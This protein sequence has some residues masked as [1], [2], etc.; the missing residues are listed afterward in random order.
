MHKSS[1]QR[2]AIVVDVRRFPPLVSA[3]IESCISEKSK[4]TL[5]VAAGLAT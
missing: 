3:Q 1:L 5:K 4:P 2:A